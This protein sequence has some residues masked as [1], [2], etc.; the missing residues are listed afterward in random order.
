MLFRW[1]GRQFHSPHS[2]RENRSC[3]RNMFLWFTQES[4]KQAVSIMPWSMPGRLIA[5]GMNPGCFLPEQDPIGLKFLMAAILLWEIFL[6][7]SRTR[8][9]VLLDVGLQGIQVGSLALELLYLL[10]NHD[11]SFRPGARRDLARI[12]GRTSIPVH[13]G[14]HGQEPGSRLGLAHQSL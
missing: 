6:K 5:E 1:S 3:P 8:L 11:V 12:H 7:S 4:P 2:E 10:T 13:R 14:S 9:Q